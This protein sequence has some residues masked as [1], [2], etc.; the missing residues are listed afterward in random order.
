LFAERCGRRGRDTEERLEQKA[1]EQKQAGG[2]GEIG[3]KR[4]QKRV[5]HGSPGAGGKNKTGKF[6]F[7]K[8]GC[9][10]AKIRGHKKR[11][12]LFLNQGPKYCIKK[13]FRQGAEKKRLGVTKKK[14]KEKKPNIGPGGGG[15]K[16]VS[17]S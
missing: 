12:F 13:N 7:S 14:R 17:E 4:K 1:R 5:G 6:T 16:Q 10:R 15:Q 9:P 8:S 2:G 3:K 11:G